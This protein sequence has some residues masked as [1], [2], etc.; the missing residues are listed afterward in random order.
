M[1]KTI[2][3][4]Y[5]SDDA[6]QFLQLHNVQIVYYQNLAIIAMD[7]EIAVVNET[8]DLMEYVVGFWTD[9]GNDILEDCVIIFLN[10]DSSETKVILRKDYWSKFLDMPRRPVVL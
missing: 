4:G 6:K 7:E 8:L 1:I 2:V 10:I 5:V 9:D 3:A